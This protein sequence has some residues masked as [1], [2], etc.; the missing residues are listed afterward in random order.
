LPK[1]ERAALHDR[2][3]TALEQQ[4]GDAQQLTEILAHH[5][6]RAFTLSAELSLE[7]DVLG[8]RARRAMEWALAMGDRARRRHE[9]WV[10]ESGLNVVRSAI[11]TLP[12]GGGLDARARVRLLEAQLLVMKAEYGE[13]GKAAAEAAALAEHAGLLPLVANRPADRGLDS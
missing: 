9:V 13:A 2:F 10:L 7:G 11:A 3:G 8:V 4:A 5:A 1:S 6:E 12:D